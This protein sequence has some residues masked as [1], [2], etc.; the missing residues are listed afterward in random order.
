MR[1][2]TELAAGDAA[3]HLGQE[4]WHLLELLGRQGAGEIRLV[5]FDDAA[6]DTDGIEFGIL[7][8]TGLLLLL[9]DL[10]VEIPNLMSV[11]VDAL[12]G[13]EVGDGPE[14]L[15]HTVLGQDPDQG[16]V[17]VEGDRS[18]VHTLLSA[19][20]ARHGDRWINPI[21]RLRVPVVRRYRGWQPS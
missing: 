14:D 21:T 10:E 8:R 4:Q 20:L 13:E 7:L 17:H 15:I 2:E 1:V 3:V 5:R 9:H 16:A 18:N 12:V 19:L 11:Q 6:P